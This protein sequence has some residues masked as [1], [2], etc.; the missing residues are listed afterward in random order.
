MA[1]P[2]RSVTDRDAP[3]SPLRPSTV[4]LWWLLLF[5]VWPL[6]DPGHSDLGSM[7]VWFDLALHWTAGAVLL[8]RA[9]DRRA[10]RRMRQWQAGPPC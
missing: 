10:A 5:G 9:I 8:D 3:A 4:L 7:L 2:D 1:L 6:A